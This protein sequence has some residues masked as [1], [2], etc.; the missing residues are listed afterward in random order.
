MNSYRL[1]SEEV[2]QTDAAVVRKLSVANTRNSN[3]EAL[4]RRKIGVLECRQAYPRMMKS[5]SLL[6]E[7]LKTS[8][9]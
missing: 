6:K 1:T 9:S 3:L 4:K 2:K 7:T 5:A 8:M